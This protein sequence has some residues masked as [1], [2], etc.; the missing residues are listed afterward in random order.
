MMAE[1]RRTD[2]VPGATPPGR[3]EQNHDVMRADASRRLTGPA[4]TDTLAAGGGLEL[5]GREPDASAVTRETLAHEPIPGERDPGTLTTRE[6]GAMGTASGA[7]RP[8]ADAAA[9]LSA[10]DIEELRRDGGG[11]SSRRHKR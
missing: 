11:L 6:P 9:S 3:G 5:P 7:E 8:P 2:E 10:D 4:S 1:K